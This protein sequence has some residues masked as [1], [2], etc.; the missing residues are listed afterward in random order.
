[1]SGWWSPTLQSHQGRTHDSPSPP[2]AC[3]PLQSYLEI[4]KLLITPYVPNVIDVTNP[5]ATVQ[6]PAMPWSKRNITLYFRGRCTLFKGDNVGKKM[7]Y[8][9]VS[10][11]PP[12]KP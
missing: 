4:S 3:C 5:L 1:M 10:N 6:R 2:D 9:L 11:T 8:H 12:P 7:R